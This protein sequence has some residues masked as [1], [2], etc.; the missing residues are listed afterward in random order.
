MSVTYRDIKA[1]VLA[2]MTRGEWRPGELLPNE[3]D[4]ARSYDCARATV[5]RALRELA[6]EGFIERKRRSGTRVKTVPSR[7]AQFDIPLIRGEI[8]A[9]GSDYGYELLR[10]QLV[11]GPSWLT[12]QMRITD[13]SPMLHIECLHLCDE[14]PFQFEDRWINLTALPEAR[15]ADFT[16][17]GPNEWLVSTVPFSDVELNFTAAQADSSIAYVL[18]C[19]PGEALFQMERSTWFEGKPVTYVRMFYHPGYRMT[20]RY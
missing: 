19:Q 7:R 13:A 9:L 8:E 6:E 14:T 3:V 20:T 10:R 16:T 18:N 17:Q 12:E 4:L 11:D 15:E 2:R 1:D 5:N